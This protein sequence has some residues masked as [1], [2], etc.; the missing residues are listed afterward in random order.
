MK[1]KT[2]PYFFIK[3]IRVELSSSRYQYLATNLQYQ[4]PFCSVDRRSLNEGRL[5]LVAAHYDGRI[6][7]I[8]RISVKDYFLIRTQIKNLFSTELKNQSMFLAVFGDLCLYIR[9][10]YD[11]GHLISIAEKYSF[12]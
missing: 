2:Y 11:S 8:P 10:N 3:R 12:P 9:I 6:E 5:T 4:I 1:T 7:I